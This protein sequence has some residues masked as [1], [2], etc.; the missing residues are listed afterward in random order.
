MGALSGRNSALDALERAVAG[1]RLSA[2]EILSLYEVPTPELAAAAHEVR[3]QRTPPNIVSYPIG[4]NIDYTSIC[5]V[6]CRFC[7]FYRAQ[8]QQ[9]AF[10]LSFD[11]IAR[12]MEAI[13]RFGGREVLIQ[14]GVNPD[15]PFDW[16][17]RLMCM[18]KRSFPGI[19]VDALSP[20]E[21]L[22]LETL[23]GRSARSLLGDLKEAGLDGMPGAAAE[24]L[25]DEVRLRVA[26]SRIRSG[27]WLRIIDA[28]QEHGLLVPWVGM[29]TG[30]GE[31]L[32]QRVDHLLLLRA[33]QD[34]ALERYDNGFVAFK[35]W[36]ARLEHTRLCRE[37]V[38]PD[39]VAEQYVREVA[40]ARLALDNVRNHRTVWRTMGFGVAQKAL[41]AGANDICATGSIN[42]IDAVMVVAG[43]GLPDPNQELLEQVRECIVA[44]GFSPALRNAHYKLLGSEH[45]VPTNGM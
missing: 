28:A 6:A 30:F 40:I 23:T 16:Y 29:V 5:T 27:D 35:V 19:H 24:I 8:H 7:L 43:R 39:T 18:L 26:P 4:G 14:G 38:S 36:P 32:M 34:R 44:A 41:R 10:T 45:L 21:V 3:L 9:G 25:V 42:A 33:Q 1:Q 13:R 20:E 22:G 17:V 37:Q 15:L 11:E 31:S 2:K 12:Q